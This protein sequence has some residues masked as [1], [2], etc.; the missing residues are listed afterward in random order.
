MGAFIIFI[1]FTDEV[2]N[3]QNIN[4]SETGKVIRNFRI[5]Q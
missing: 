1:S 4:Q 2:S 3:F 5:S